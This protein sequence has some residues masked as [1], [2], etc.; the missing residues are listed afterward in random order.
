[1]PC[2]IETTA[3]GVRAMVTMKRSRSLSGE[4]PSGSVSLGSPSL[5]GGLRVSR[6]QAIKLR[7]DLIRGVSLAGLTVLREAFLTVQER[8]QGLACACN[9]AFYSTDG[10]IADRRSIFIG[11][12][13]RPNENECFAL[14]VREATQSARRVRKLRGP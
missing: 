8:D 14:F 2:R 12:T 10:A 4:T 11:E 6:N 9:A 3:I 5:V 7:H 13:A 1:M